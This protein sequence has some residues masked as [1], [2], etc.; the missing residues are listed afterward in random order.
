MEEEGRTESRRVGGRPSRDKGWEGGATRDSE[1]E[2]RLQS[3]G[4]PQ[5]SGT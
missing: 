2:V 5:S 4:S 1:R 3:G